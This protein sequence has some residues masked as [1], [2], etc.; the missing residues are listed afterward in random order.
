MMQQ[1][2]LVGAGGFLGAITRFLTSR[3]TS[4]MLGSFPIG[5]LIVNV[6]GSF[7][8][9][10]IMYSVLNDSRMISPEFRSFAAIGFMGA[11]TTMSTFAYESF[12]FIDLRDMTLFSLNIAMNIVLCLFAIYLGKEVALLIGGIIK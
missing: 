9:G 4:G 11:F 2:L 8:L 1:I 10:L 12:R 5:T 6:S 3:Y 7:L